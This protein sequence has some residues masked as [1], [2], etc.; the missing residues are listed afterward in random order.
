V[1]YIKQ[2]RTSLENVWNLSYKIS[3]LLICM[4]PVHSVTFMVLP[5][6]TV[7]SQI[8]PFH[9]ISPTHVDSNE[10]IIQRLQM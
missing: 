1:R 10:R 7:H 6:H 4:M 8:I 2:Y 9:T 3:F 5:T